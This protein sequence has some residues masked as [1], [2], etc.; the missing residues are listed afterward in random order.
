[1]ESK[2][3]FQKKKINIKNCTPFYFDDLIKLEDIVKLENI[4]LDKK[5]YKNILVY[6]ILCKKYMDANPLRIMFDKVDGIFKIYNGIRY[7]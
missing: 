3:E 1:M 4:F 6:N 5:S 2:N 7:I